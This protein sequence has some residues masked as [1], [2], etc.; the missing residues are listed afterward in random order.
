MDLAQQC[1]VDQAA[2]C[3]S[4]GLPAACAWK[5]ASDGGLHVGADAHR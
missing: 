2:L 4:L 5:A 1:Q 3:L